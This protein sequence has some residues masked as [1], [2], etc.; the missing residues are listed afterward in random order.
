[1]ESSLNALGLLWSRLL[2]CVLA[3]LPLPSDVLDSMT[4]RLKV[5]APSA[6][7]K[8]GTITHSKMTEGSLQTRKMMTRTAKMNSLMPPNFKPRLPTSLSPSY[9]HQ[10]QRKRTRLYH[11]LSPPPPPPRV[12]SCP[13]RNS[14]FSLV[15][16]VQRLHPAQPSKQPLRS[17]S[18]RQKRRVGGLSR[19]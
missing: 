4:F 11:R 6:R 3:L 10:R 17:R 18:R 2:Q 16:P 14:L 9:T 5:L 15:P 12:S 1:M 19:G 13:H 7:I 8:P